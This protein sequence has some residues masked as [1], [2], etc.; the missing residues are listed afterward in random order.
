MKF[1]ILVACGI[2]GL[3]WLAA[4]QTQTVDYWTRMP[5]TVASFNPVSSYSDQNV[6]APCGVVG[7]FSQK[8]I[9]ALDADIHA[10]KVVNDKLK[11][12][13]PPECARELHNEVIAAWT[14]FSEGFMLERD[15]VANALPLGGTL[16]ELSA[17]NKDA[18]QPVYK[19]I[20][21]ATHAMGKVTEHARIVKQGC[22]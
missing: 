12:I 1:G 13:A 11:S 21:D 18:L 5:S 16:D 7:Q 10:L 14:T 4:P 22:L 6:A 20:S 3:C 2:A 15:V 17:R 19:K 8:C 9:E